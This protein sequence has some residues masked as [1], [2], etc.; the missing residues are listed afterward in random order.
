MPRFDNATLVLPETPDLQPIF[1]MGS[2]WL[3]AARSP[4]PASKRADTG[5]NFGP[6]FYDSTSP[7]FGIPTF[8]P[9]VRADGS[10][11]QPPLEPLLTDSPVPVTAVLERYPNFE[12]YYSPVV[13]ATN[14]M[15]SDRLLLCED[16]QS[17]LDRLECGFGSP[18]FRRDGPRCRVHAGRQRRRCPRA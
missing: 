2:A 17:E 14:Q 1:P 4:T 9:P 18:V 13:N 7:S 8:F 11:L 12:K 6:G 15:T 16:M 10:P 5:F 3:P